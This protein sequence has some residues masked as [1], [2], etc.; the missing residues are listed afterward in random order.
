MAP[1]SATVAGS[2]FGAAIVPACCLDTVKVLPFRHP[3]IA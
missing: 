2:A 1:L 3:A